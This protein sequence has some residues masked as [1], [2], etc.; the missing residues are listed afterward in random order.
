[1][2]RV[3]ETRGAY[4]CPAMVITPPWNNLQLKWPEYSIVN[5]LYFVTKCQPNM[6]LN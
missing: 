4:S 5:E 6:Q 3:G 2:R 1:M